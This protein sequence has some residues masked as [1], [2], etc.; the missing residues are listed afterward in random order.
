MDEVLANLLDGDELGRAVVKLAQMPDTSQVSLD[1][2][3][4]NRRPAGQ[5]DGSD[6]W[7]SQAC[8]EMVAPSYELRYHAS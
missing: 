4:A 5:A 1:S 2:A 7:A 6:N 3:R 8:H